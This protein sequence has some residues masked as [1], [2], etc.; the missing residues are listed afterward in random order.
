MISPLAEPRRSTWRPQP[1]TCSASTSPRTAASIPCSRANGDPGPNFSFAE[2]FIDFT[3]TGGVGL[4]KTFSLEIGDANFLGQ[5][6]ATQTA[7]QLD[8]KW[9][10]VG[11]SDASQGGWGVTR[12]NADGSI[13][14]SY[15]TGVS[16]LGTTI[17]GVSDA[18]H[19]RAQI[20]ADGR[21]IVGGTRYTQNGT[22]ELQRVSSELPQVSLNKKGTLIVYGSNDAETVTLSI[23]AKDGR[24]ILRDN[25]FSQSLAPSRV[26]R[27]ALFL[28]GGDDSV[29]NSL[30]L[31]GIYA[32]LGAGNDTANGGAGNDVFLGGAGDDTLFGNGGNDILVAGDGNDYALGGSGKD[33]LFGGNGNDTLNGAGGNDRL[34]GEAGADHLSG[35]AGTDESDNDPAD[36]RDTIETLLT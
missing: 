19:G 33:D 15:G 25:T 5:F 36:T 29:T 31:K 13:D 22:F 18:G 8:G 3:P 23:R 21:I 7:R 11:P 12:L 10:L 16:R 2:T 20:A 34:F 17:V 4:T 1:T 26:K 24:L 35:G 9:L 30:P 14:T 6:T 28:Y 27:I 32:D